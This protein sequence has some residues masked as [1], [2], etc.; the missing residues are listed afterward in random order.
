ME[1]T[2]LTFNTKIWTV[3][4]PDDIAVSQ[5]NGVLELDIKYNKASL[6]DKQARGIDTITFTPKVTRLHT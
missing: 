2:E 4:A 1:S 5:K 6:F 3:T